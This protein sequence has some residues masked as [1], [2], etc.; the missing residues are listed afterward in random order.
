M[1][2]HIILVRIK[3]NKTLREVKLVIKKIFTVLKYSHKHPGMPQSIMQTSLLTNIFP[4]LFSILQG[5]SIKNSV[6]IDERTDN[7]IF[8]CIG[9][10][11]VC[12]FFVILL[13][14]TLS[15]ECKCCSQSL[16]CNSPDNPLLGLFVQHIFN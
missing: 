1:A 5:K 12:P 11:M 3:V 13:G 14:K 4:Q 9:H 16:F 6:Y 8:L 7:P 2:E 15:N 10:E